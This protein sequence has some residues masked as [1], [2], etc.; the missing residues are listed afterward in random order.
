MQPL[1]RPIDYA[2]AFR[3]RSAIKRVCISPDV[4]CRIIDKRFHGVVAM[5]RIAGF[6]V[7]DIHA[8]Q[9]GHA[10]I[11]RA[12]QMYGYADHLSPACSRH[13]CGVSLNKPIVSIVKFVSPRANV[14]T[15]KRPLR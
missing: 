15:F 3:N 2:S 8:R 11:I 1:T 10:A 5:H 14:N 9:F 4:C 13:V 7:A 6:I 12:D